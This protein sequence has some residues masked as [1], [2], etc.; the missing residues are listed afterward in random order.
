MW[1]A[2]CMMKLIMHAGKTGLISGRSHVA[3]TNA[4]RRENER[5][6][7]TF[8]AACYT[9]P[10]GR[11]AQ[12][13]AQVLYT[14]KAG[15]SNPSSPTIDRNTAPAMVPFLVRAPVRGIRTPWGLMLRKARERL[16]QHESQGCRRHPQRHRLAKRDGDIPHRPPSK[17]GRHQ[18]RCRFLL[19]PLSEGFEPEGREAEKMRWAFSSEARKEA[20]RASAAGGRLRSRR[21]TSLIAH[22]GNIAVRISAARRDSNPQNASSLCYRGS[23]ISTCRFV[24]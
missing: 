2:L 8:A 13:L 12:R 17:P 1:T 11:L 7:P 3:R 24:H 21:P 5:H 14:H 15:G 9:V 16:C 19:E 22:P 23:H 6:A 18:Q 4:F 10:H 20:R